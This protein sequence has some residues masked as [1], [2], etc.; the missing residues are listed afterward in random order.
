[1]TVEDP[2]GPGAGQSASFDEARY[3]S[4]LGHFA[5]GV[6]VVSAMDGGEPVGLSVNSFTSAS[7]DPPLVAFCA[8][9]TSSTWPRIREAGRFTVNVLAEHQATVS[10]VFATH[11]DDKYEGLR[12]SPAPSGAPV[13]EG[14]L[15]WVDCTIEAEHDAGDHVLVLGR[16]NDLDVV[17][18]GGPLIFYRGGYGRIER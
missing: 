17:D 5:T 12:W 4:V 2:L 18:E 15:A 14:V 13:L 1:M 3:R 9:K 7:L 11:R 8:A 6:T 16:V 10:R